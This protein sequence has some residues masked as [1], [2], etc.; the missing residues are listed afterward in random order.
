MDFTVITPTGDRPEALGLCEKYLHRQTLQPKEWLV[1]DDGD[2]PF[3]FTHPRVK[4]L[5]RVNDL[6]H[7]THTLRKQMLYALQHVTTDFVII[8]EDDDWYG[9]RHLASI[10]E[11]LQ[12]H[13]LV[14][15]S[16]T[17][18][19]NIR[20]LTWKN[21]YNTGTSSWCQMGFRR[22]LFPLIERLCRTSDHPSLDLHLWK[23]ARKKYPLH[24]N[25]RG[26]VGIKGMPG[27]KGL[28]PS[29][30]E[31]RGNSDK[32]LT[33]FY[34]IIGE[35]IL[36]YEQFM[37]RP[38]NWDALLSDAREA[39]NVSRRVLSDKTQIHV[40][41]DFGVLPS[42]GVSQSEE[43]VLRNNGSDGVSIPREGTSA[44]LMQSLPGGRFMAFDPG[45]VPETVGGIKTIARDDASFSLPRCPLQL[46]RQLDQTYRRIGR[47]LRWAIK[48][49]TDTGLFSTF[50]NAY[51][52]WFVGKGPSIDNL[53]LD[54]FDREGPIICINE[55]IHAV[56]DLLDAIS[57]EE[58][59]AFLVFHPLFVMQQDI[60]LGSTC[61][62][63]YGRL[64]VSGRSAKFY[65]DLE[66]KIIFSPE[67]LLNQTTVITVQC[68]IMF[69]RGYGA[70][71]F[72]FIGFDGAFGEKEY[73]RRIGY[74]ARMG[75]R[76][77]RFLGHKRLI[78]AAL[79]PCEA[80]FIQA[81]PG[82]DRVFDKS[83]QPIYNRR[84]HCEVV[85]DQQSLQHALQSTKAEALDTELDSL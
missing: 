16:P 32:S 10:L 50:G 63:K 46:Q 80:I 45:K 73:A 56:E 9:P 40:S 43:T 78:D 53:R 41:S 30:T 15:E 37:D 74:D 36:N 26:C 39:A 28:T 29:H 23:A 20:L 51:G 11:A 33:Y 59:Q 64:I 61:H 79:G 8:M 71:S 6:P 48:I 75:G 5:R 4:H 18:Y 54:H 21:W 66:D 81:L 55:S 44:D 57:E 68:A 58:R 14:G 52:C 69:A 84:E 1:V 35:D 60:T 70:K 17:I 72:G 13:E 7:G 27:R 67:Q 76:K 38:E 62:P 49:A 77:D 19:Y 2:T 22:S 12:R 24:H 42:K 65:S 47:K 85:T 83:L 82:E 34:K 3:S 25:V 31:L